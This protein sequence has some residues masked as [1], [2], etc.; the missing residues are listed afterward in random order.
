MG[1]GLT[2]FELGMNI[3]SKE[4]RR[5]LGHYPTGVCA[6]TAT[7]TD[8]KPVG[9]VVG[10]FTSVSLD[11]M[12]VAFFPD[13]SSTTWPKVE[14]AGRFCVNVLGD[15]QQHVCASLAA[16]G[17]EKFANI[18]FD[19]SQLGSPIIDGA[20]AW[21]DCELETVHEAGDHFIVLGLV[22][23]LDLQT[24]GSPLIFHKGGYS[25]VLPI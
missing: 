8:G 16:K 9:L 12:L 3:E 2:G 13:R 20:L 14:A 11:P 7:G 15:D 21:I 25:K 22:R 23:S 17:D 24:E 4:F 19:L 1:Q 5:I 10:S 6:V 18:E